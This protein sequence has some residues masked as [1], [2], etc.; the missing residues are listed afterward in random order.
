MGKGETIGRCEHGRRQSA[1][2]SRHAAH[3]AVTWSATKSGAKLAVPGKLPLRT[4]RIGEAMGSRVSLG[5]TLLSVPPPCAGTCR[6]AARRG[7][8]PAAL[9]H[10]RPSRRCGGKGP[11]RGRD[12]PVGSKE[13]GVGMKHQHN[14]GSA[15]QLSVPCALSH[16][17]PLV[18]PP[19]ELTS[20]AE[21]ERTRLCRCCCGPADALMRLMMLREH[22]ADRRGASPRDRLR[23][24]LPAG[25]PQTLAQLLRRV[26]TALCMIP[27]IAKAQT[28]R[29]ECNH[30]GGSRRSGNGGSGEGARG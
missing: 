15:Q 17:P 21:A 25:A 13:A 16:S 11:R 22:A 28:Q 3:S 26:H 12:H 29:G 8:P 23:S 9:L 18:L 14:G 20:S 19:A 5:S 30:E 7:R 10:P 4:C 24:L 27:A 2:A 6:P 1:N